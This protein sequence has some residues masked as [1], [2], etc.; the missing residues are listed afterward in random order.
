MRTDILENRTLTV[1]YDGEEEI[2]PGTP[3]LGTILMKSDNRNVVFTPH[4][5]TRNR[6]TVKNPLVFDGALLSS[7][8]KKNGRYSIHAVI[9]TGTDFEKARRTAHD[10]LDQLFDRLKAFRP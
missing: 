8:F 9:N 3:Q 7:R 10:E 4:C 6:S 2:V 5:E 1:I